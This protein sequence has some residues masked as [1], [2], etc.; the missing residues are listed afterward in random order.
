MIFHATYDDRLAFEVRQDA[1]KVTMHFVA[2]RFV[3]QK[4]PTI[5]C[6]EYSMNEDFPERLCHGPR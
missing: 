5:L 2:Q 3:A 1:A 6:G 4:W